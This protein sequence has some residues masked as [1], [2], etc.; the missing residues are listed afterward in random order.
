[1]RE[2]QSA[3]QALKEAEATRKGDNLQ[4]LDARVQMLQ[5]EL[6]NGTIT[7]AERELLEASIPQL[8]QLRD[9]N[10]AQLPR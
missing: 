4:I 1:M 9:E 6:E 10:L 7:P 5:R 8:N 3:S 2:T